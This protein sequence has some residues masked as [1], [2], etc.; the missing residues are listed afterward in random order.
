MGIP[1]DKTFY[2][3]TMAR[4]YADQG[5]YEEAVRIYRYLL[6]QTPDRSDLIQALEA[7]T[8][9]LPDIPSHWHDISDLIER[10]AGLMLRQN[11]YR[12]LKKIR[13]PS[14]DEGV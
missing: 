5:R 2:T 1:G 14:V 12:R 8:S 9:M 11:T 10:W 6:D 7:A 4:V 13:V 3:V